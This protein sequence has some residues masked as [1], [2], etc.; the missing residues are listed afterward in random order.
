MLFDLQ[1]KRK[2][3]IR[4]V[5]VVLAVMFVVGFLGSGVGTSGSGGG[6]FFDLFGFGGGSSSL[7]QDQIDDAEQQVE[8][9]ELTGGKRAQRAALLDLAQANF[10]FAS[11]AEGVDAD[12]QGYTEKG[13]Q[14]ATGGVDA[15]EQ[16]LK[17]KP[18]KPD[19]GVA[20][21]AARTYSL[22]GDPRGALKAQKIV[23]EANPE[24]PVAWEELGLYAYANG[25]DDLGGE[26]QAKTL[27]LVPKDQRNTVEAQL[28]TE[29]KAGRTFHRDSEARERARRE[30]GNDGDDN[31]GQPL[32][33]QGG[34]HSTPG[35]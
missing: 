6:G 23:V 26:A 34:G 33:G 14:A 32:P 1:G 35:G 25:D 5:Y 4:V 28:D 29:R 9:A 22:L 16:Y 10:T 7:L 18:S 2:N 31:F 21:L 30:Q 13:T 11:S 27:A 24:A 8:R 20:A 3:F 12:A 19:A 15:W 17:T